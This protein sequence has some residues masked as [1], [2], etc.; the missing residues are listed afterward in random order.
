MKKIATVFYL[1]AWIFFAVLIDAIYFWIWQ[2]GED[3]DLGWWNA[4]LIGNGL[5]LLP[6]LILFI[7]SLTL[8]GAAWSRLR[9]A[10]GVG[11]DYSRLVGM[12]IPVFNYGWIFVAVWG[13]AMDYND[14]LK[15]RNWSLPRVN[16][17]V[18]FIFC[19]AA[20]LGSVLKYYLIW[21]DY[22]DVT[23]TSQGA[24][25]LIS[26]II[27]IT[28]AIVIAEIGQGI[29][30][31]PLPTPNYV[32]VPFSEA[33]D[34]QPVDTSILGRDNNC[35]QCGALIK[36]ND[37][38]FCWNCGSGLESPGVLSPT[39]PNLSHPPEMPYTCE[40][41]E[42]PSWPSP[43]A[44]PESIDGGSISSERYTTQISDATPRNKTA[45]EA[46]VTLKQC[47]N[48][49]CALFSPINART[50]IHCG[51]HFAPNNNTQS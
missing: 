38:L 6:S 45:N 42:T 24:I 26:S 39:A 44:A 43:D 50:C 7:I 4:L 9:A 49:D 8:I 22:P 21:R 5:I 41:D 15:R 33:T 29:N 35:R 1:S 30:R 48:S 2:Y 11:I 34:R 31:L 16:S 18:F 37:A 25:W 47:P 17:S 3:F 19:L 12:F 36:L 20:V 46:A 10:D 32:R 51:T 13:L 40:N 14:L 27:F 23:A 28:G